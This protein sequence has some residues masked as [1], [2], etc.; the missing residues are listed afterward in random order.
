[1]S[2]RV[3]YT[4]ITAV[5]ELAIKAGEAQ[6]GI[7]AESYAFQREMQANEIDAQ[8]KSQ[9]RDIQFRRQQ[10]MANFVTNLQA[11]TVAAGQSAAAASGQTAAAGAQ[12]AGQIFASQ[13]AMR[14]NRENL[15]FEQERL[16]FDQ[17]LQEQAHQL[18][19][20]ADE[21]AERIITQK[22]QFQQEEQ[23]LGLETLQSQK[24][25]LARTTQEWMENKDSIIL[26][27]GM[28]AYLAGLTSLQQGKAPT[29]L[30]KVP[31]AA[32]EAKPYSS[33]EMKNWTE[34]VK[35]DMARDLAGTSGYQ[36]IQLS[37]ERFIQ[38]AA[39]GSE[40]QLRQLEDAFKTVVGGST[41]EAGGMSMPANEANA[42]AKTVRDRYIP[43]PAKTTTAAPSYDWA[44]ITQQEAILQLTGEAG[45]GKGLLEGTAV[46]TTPVSQQDINEWAFGSQKKAELQRS[47]DTLKPTSIITKQPIQNLSPSQIK[48][49]WQDRFTTKEWDRYTTT[50]RTE[51]LKK[52]QAAK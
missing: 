47:T 52:Y 17:Q 22:L 45:V 38:K 9:Q 6:R 34:M 18:E 31:T 3:N 11:Q 2:I 8:R 7:R 48:Q 39:P 1:M 36:E 41:K 49:M 51:M 19:L 33:A 37:Y 10:Y 12:A 29:T 32:K 26:D 50:E 14:I 23:L 27:Y 15:A 28:P 16:D 30:P 43:P 4:P 44:K 42:I 20:A 21:R 13:N 40:K 24:E 35:A 25:K 46:D 5:G